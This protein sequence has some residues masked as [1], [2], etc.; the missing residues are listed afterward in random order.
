[1]TL[2]SLAWRN[3]LRRPMRTA[4]TI[5]G[6]SLAIGSALA[7]IA[8][9]H[10]IE[11]STRASM[12][13]NGTDLAVTQLGADDLFGG[14]L[15][16]ALAGPLEK[17][18]GVQRVS[19]ELFM[20]APS[21]RNRQVILTGWPEASTS[22]KHMPLRNGR[23]PQPGE[24]HVAVVG[25]LVADVLGKQVGDTIELLG[26]PFKVIGISKFS[27]V[28]NRGEVLVPLKDLQDLTYRTGQV[29]MFS[30]TLQH[31]ASKSEIERVRNDI[32]ALGRVTVSTPGE[33]LQ[34]DRNIGTLRAVSRVV[35]VI[36]LIM[37]VVSVH[38]T[39]LMSTQERT[40]EIGIVAAVGW[41]D[42][43]IMGSILIEGLLICAFGCAVG[44]VLS[45]LASFFLHYVPTIGDYLEFRPSL[46][47]ILPTVLATF[48]LCAAGS[49]YP[50]WRAVRMTP[51]EALQRV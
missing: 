3:L 48:A 7:L 8:L 9:S 31:E 28:I 50:A 32:A 11:D 34:N 19:A 22:W 4:L 10:S 15:S 35:T 18:P 30:V 41:N 21:E 14:Y 39:L 17:I 27:S 33:V 24:R 23:T 43:L 49:L 38:N 16:E 51:A 13:E 40:R 2:T 44:V 42:R 1:M 47:L 36:A 29:T 25:D 5:V 6:V 20:F 26:T 45:Y 37:G 12:A 46:G